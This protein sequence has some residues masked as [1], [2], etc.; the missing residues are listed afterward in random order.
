MVVRDLRRFAR[1]FAMVSRDLA[2]IRDD[3]RDLSVRPSLISTRL[4]EDQ[5]QMSEDRARI[6]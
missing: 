2:K 4:C 1:E 6:S 3:V 5:P